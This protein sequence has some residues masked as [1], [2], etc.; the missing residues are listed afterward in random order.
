M[1]YLDA[2]ALVKRYIEEE[3]SESVLRAMDGADSW[4]MC[5]I[6]YVET[7]RAVALA[8]GRKSVERVEKD[9][10]SFDVVEIDSALAE[11]AAKLTLSAGL[12]SLDALHLAAALLLP[13]ENLTIA[14]WDAR[15]HHAAQDRGMETLPKAL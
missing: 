2:S 10:P 9:W 1:L 6:G 13:S 7:I 5:R 12:R 15:L 11:D 14:T 8:G 3:G 4:S